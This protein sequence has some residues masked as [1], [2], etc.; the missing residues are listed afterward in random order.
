MKQSG[1]LSEII[2]SV[3]DTFSSAKLNTDQRATVPTDV[4]SHDFGIARA[5][6]S[7]TRFSNQQWGK[8]LELGQK[9]AWASNRVIKKRLRITPWLCRRRAHDGDLFET[10]QKLIADFKKIQQRKDSRSTQTKP[11]SSQT[12]K[13]TE[14]EKSR[15][16]GCTSRSFLV[17][18]R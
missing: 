14:Q 8:T 11:K 2:R 16:T 13:Q 17:K 9:R 7:S 1:D 15:S 6:S 5:V 12:R 10:A 4:E 3:N 18:E